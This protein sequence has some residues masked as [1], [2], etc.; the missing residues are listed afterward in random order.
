M[1]RTLLDFGTIEFFGRSLPL[2]VYGYGLMLVFGFLAGIALARWR[3]RRAGENPEHVSHVAILGLIGGVVGSRLAYVIENYDTFARAERPLAAML[4]ISS[5]GLIY[6][7]GV[8][9]ALALVIGYLLV[10]RLPIRRFLDIVAVSVMVGLAFGRA[11][12]LLNGCCWGGPAEHN[13]P[14]AA[15]FPMYSQPLVKLDGR[16]NPFSAATESPSPV[17]VDQHSRGVVHPDERLVNPYVTHRLEDEDGS[18]VELHPLLPPRDLHGPLE[19]DQLSVVL[20]EP[21]RTA[22]LFAELAGADARLSRAEWDRGLAAGDGLLRGSEQW[23][24][25]TRRRF[26]V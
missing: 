18:V 15:V 7:G 6:Y 26:D 22:R 8:V 25:A 1:L 5:G 24:V 4:N 11:G 21:E 16:E 13:S 10:K 23:E 3:A 9:L 19:T 20:G 17:Y 14:I 12:C 2:R